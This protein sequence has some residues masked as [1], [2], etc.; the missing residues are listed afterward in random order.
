MQLAQ[1][2]SAVP[3][4]LHCWHFGSRKFFDGETSILFRCLVSFPQCA[5]CG[6]SVITTAPY[7]L[8]LA[9]N[10]LR[11]RVNEE[12][13][14]GCEKREAIQIWAS[15][16]LSLWNHASITLLTSQIFFLTLDLVL[17]QITEKCALIWVMLSS[18]QM[19]VMIYYCE[20]AP[21]GFLK[22][23]CEHTMQ[24]Y[25]IYMVTSFH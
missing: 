21:N 14:L 24:F 18:T 22:I 12:P 1:L 19:E 16:G 10:H 8:Q 9:A 3:Q 11:F 20:A 5:P 6:R 7:W 15:R 17:C 25:L 2:L 13:R 23:K 4:P